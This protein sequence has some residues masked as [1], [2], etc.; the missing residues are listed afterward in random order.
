MK[1][2]IVHVHIPMYDYW[3]SCTTK[4]EN[5]PVSVHVHNYVYLMQ[6]Y[7][8]SGLQYNFHTD[9]YI[10]QESNKLELYVDMLGLKDA[11][12]ISPEQQKYCTTQPS[13]QSLPLTSAVTLI[14]PS[15]FRQRHCAVQPQRHRSC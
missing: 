15:S 7:R 1:T 4:P 10:F 13:N 2:H 9:I 14:L 12:Q 6:K 11:S 5:P 3:C 8:Q